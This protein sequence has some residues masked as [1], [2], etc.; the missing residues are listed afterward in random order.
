MRAGRRS[1]RALLTIDT[2]NKSPAFLSWAFYV[3]ELQDEVLLSKPFCIRIVPPPRTINAK[4][5]AGMR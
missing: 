2:K 4:K 1:S 3:P 5:K